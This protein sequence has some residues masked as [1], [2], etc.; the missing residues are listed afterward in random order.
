MISARPAP[1]DISALLLSRDHIWA[2]P[3][4]RMRYKYRPDLPLYLVQVRVFT[5]PEPVTI[6]NDR[7]YKGCRSLVDLYQDI[8]PNTLTLLRKDV[9]GNWEAVQ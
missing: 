5:L 6:P 2:E 8:D 7:R 4:L 9:S 1:A 3:Y